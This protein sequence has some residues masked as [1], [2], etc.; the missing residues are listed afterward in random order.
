MAA[1]ARIH[2]HADVRVLEV[3]G[4]SEVRGLRIREPAG[5]RELPCTGVVIKAGV[6]PNS[7]WCRSGIAH[8]AAGYL[9]VNGR[10]ATSAPGVWAAGDV[11]RPALPSIPVAMSHGAEAIANI[12]EAL[13]KN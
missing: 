4:D 3:L 8:D 2:V 12:R 10:H 6:I 5:E 11:T 7:E 1:S 13:E 9:S